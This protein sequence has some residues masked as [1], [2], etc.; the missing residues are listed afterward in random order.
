MRI[1]GFTGVTTHSTEAIDWA[2]ENRMDVANLSFASVDG[3][4]TDPDAV[5]AANAVANGV[6]IVAAAGSGAKR[7]SS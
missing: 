7:G 5:A 3:R 4:E 6:V 2:L 1:F